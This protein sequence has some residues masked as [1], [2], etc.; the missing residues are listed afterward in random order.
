MEIVKL[1]VVVV[2]AVVLSGIFE[3]W[4][5]RERRHIPIFDFLDSPPYT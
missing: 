1:V 3:W 5:G 4:Q 2:F